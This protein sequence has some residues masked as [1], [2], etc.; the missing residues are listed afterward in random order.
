MAK[1]SLIIVV[2][3]SKYPQMGA[4][5]LAHALSKVNIETHIVSSDT[6]I[7]EIDALINRVDPI[8]VACSVMTAPEIVE[9]VQISVH[10]QETYN[11]RK[12]KIPVFLGRNASNNC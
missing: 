4:L 12:K 7:K 6:P 5:Y 1:Y 11:Q 2:Q 10:I 3:K 9:F 8:A